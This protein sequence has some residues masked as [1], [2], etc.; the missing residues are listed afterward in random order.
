MPFIAQNIDGNTVGVEPEEIHDEWQDVIDNYGEPQVLI[1]DT[2][3]LVKATRDKPWHG[4]KY[5]DPILL[6]TRC[7][8]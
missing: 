8:E 5:G 7:R 2:V 3:W 6:I 1:P 4:Y